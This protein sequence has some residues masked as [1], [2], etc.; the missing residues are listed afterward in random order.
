M[1][2]VSQVLEDRRR[3]IPSLAPFVVLALLFHLGI[4]AAIVISA[5]L[6]PHRPIR[7]PSVSVRLVQMPVGR[8][9]RG[10]QATRPR[11]TAVPTAAPQPTVAPQ[12]T[13]P[14]AKVERSATGNAM[15]DLEA[16]P[17]PTPP[18]AEP[19]A[20]SGTGGRGL[21]LAGESTG[22]APAIPEDFHFAYYVERM[23]ALIESRWYKP[24]APPGTTARVR[25]RIL[26][27]GRVTDIALEES[28]GVP[29]FDRAALRALYAANPLPPLPPAYRKP[30]LTVHL[31]FTE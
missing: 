5:R 12:P 30:S 8:R 23:L 31:A 7:L 14:P 28:S 2:P 19:A 27:D 13:A 4:A 25:F 6:T 3:L 21:V 17:A 10:R 24:P 16:T 26:S 1:D 20:E 9:P 18:P 15:A 22:G 11:P 29:S